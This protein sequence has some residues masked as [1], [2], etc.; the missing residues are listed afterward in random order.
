MG[1]LK[2][3]ADR[4][5]RGELSVDEGLHDMEERL[6]TRTVAERQRPSDQDGVAT[7]A[8]A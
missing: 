2:D 4:I 7:C 8:D 3:L 6:R 1:G 5:A